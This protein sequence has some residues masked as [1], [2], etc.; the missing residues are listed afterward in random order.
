MLNSSLSPEGRAGGGGGGG[1]VGGKFQFI[2]AL[3]AQAVIKIIVLTYF[4]CRS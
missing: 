4:F 1:G 3:R 2:D